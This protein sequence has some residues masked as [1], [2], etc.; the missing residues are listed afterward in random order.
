[1]SSVI[2]DGHHVSW[3]SIRLAHRLMGPNLFLITDAVVESRA[4]HY[5]YLADKGRFVTEDGTLAG[6]GGGGRGVLYPG[7]GEGERV[8]HCVGRRRSVRSG[9]RGS[10][11]REAP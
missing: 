11:P 3:A 5:R 8:A 2:A 7:G 6:K 1:M 9:V 10:G 4:G